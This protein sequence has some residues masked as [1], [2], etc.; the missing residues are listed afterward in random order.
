MTDL[1][2]NAE[3]SLQGNLKHQADLRLQGI[4]WNQEKGTWSHK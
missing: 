2:I 1:K 4:F 3:V